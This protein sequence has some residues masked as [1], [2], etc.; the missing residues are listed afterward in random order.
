MAIHRSG[1]ANPVYVLCLRGVLDF[2]AGE[3]YVL[4]L[5]LGTMYVLKDNKG[6]DTVAP[7]DAFRVVD[8]KV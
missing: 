2:K 7:K 5:D 3:K 4:V 8:V 1:L 6:Q